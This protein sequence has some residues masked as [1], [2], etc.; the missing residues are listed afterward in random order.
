[1]R[2]TNDQVAR[3]LG[4]ALPTGLSS[5]ARLAGVSIDSRTVGRGELFFA[6]HGPSHD[7]HTFV[8]QSLV[9]GAGAAVV[10]QSRLGEYAAEI[11]EKL[12]AVPDT[13]AA[14]QQLARAIRREWGGRVA[15]VA[16]SVGKTT[17]KE[18]LAA[19]VA[20]RFRTLKTEGNLNNEYGLPLTL[21]KLEPEHE[22]AVVELGMSRRGELARLTQIAE[23]QVGLI[24]RIAIEHLEFFA[25]LDEIA[26]AEREL[27]ENLP[28]RETVAV[29]NADDPFTAQFAGFAPG[30]V[31]TFGLQARADFR[32]EA[33]ED[34]GAEGS[35]F[36]FVAPEG[37]AKLKLSLV[38]RHNVANALAALA[39]ASVWGIGAKE[40][41]EVLPHM[42]PAAMRGE[43]LRFEEGF[44]VIN[45]S[46]NS[47]PTAMASV[48]DLLANTPG[49]RRRIL[50]AGEMLELGPASAELHREAGRY[51][52]AKK[53]DYVI[54]VQGDASE[55]VKAAAAG[56]MSDNILA[57]CLNSTA[58][59]AF[60]AG[61]VQKGDLVLV[62]G[63]RGVR[64]ER[65]IDAIRAK[66]ALIDN[67]AGV[68]SAAEP[69]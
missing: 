59:G 28:G 45:D 42:K 56:G 12:F 13:L 67:G 22:A 52:A 32:V 29:L 49:Y 36:T 39:A 55:I 20:A 38:G 2:W 51:A 10:A 44:T 19:L 24:T 3:A 6:I 4:V 62:K 30:R 64:M 23:P 47:S 63:S 40:A 17:T 57:F 27:I 16:G 41:A 48:I 9:A 65:V 50:V 37:R 34:L 1:M 26:L 21:A 14:L 11:R 54:A 53:L 46:Y 5:V 8:A 7:G 61:F 31:V 35:E 68:P 69:H 58:A 66:H 18:I 43:V 60:L 15:A 33:I 25:S